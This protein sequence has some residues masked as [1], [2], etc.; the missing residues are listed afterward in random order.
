MIGIAFLMDN[1]VS[2]R[3]HES[4]RNTRAIACVCHP[5]QTLGE[6]DSCEPYAMQ[7]S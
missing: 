6:A 7:P 2:H 5:A 1:F 3:S 4:H